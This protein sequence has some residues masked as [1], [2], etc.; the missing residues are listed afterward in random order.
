MNTLKYPTGTF[1]FAKTCTDSEIPALIEQIDA[2]PA[3]LRSAVEGM[4][5]EKLHSSYRPG[6]WTL[7]QVVHHIADSHMNGYIRFRLA[8]T[9]DCPPVKPYDEETWAQ[10]DDAAHMPVEVSL[11]L[12]EALHQRWVWLLRSLDEVQFDARFHHP[13]NGDVSLRTTTALYAWHGNHH[14][15]HILS[16]K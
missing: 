3:L 8:L 2:L 1:D 4:S 9:E 6:G 7:K 11:Q 15:A 10:L 5:D 14:L 12:I 13:V 16:A